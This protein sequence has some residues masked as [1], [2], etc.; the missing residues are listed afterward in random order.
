M[1]IQATPEDIQALE[2]LYHK[3]VD[4]NDA[5]GIHQ[6]DHAEVMWKHLAE[7]YEISDFYVVKHDD[8]IIA[9]AS[10]VDYDPRYWPQIPPK[11][12]L[13]LHKLCVD[14][15]YSKQG[16]STRLLNFFKAKGRKEGYPDVR[17][18][19]RSHKKKLRAMYEAQGFVHVETLSLFE[20]YDT[21]LYRFDLK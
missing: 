16:F 9:A 15:Q 2:R 1:I 12:S 13:Y 17:L 5:Q 7:I 6:W 8:E 18:D 14:P 20:G 3:R 4:Y 21:A 10:I 19:V 11:Q